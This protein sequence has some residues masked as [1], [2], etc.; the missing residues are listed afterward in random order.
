MKKPYCLLFFLFMFYGNFVSKA[1]PYPNAWINFSSGGT[2]S[3]QLYFRIK[4]GSE[5]IYRITSNTMLLSGISYEQMALMNPDLIQIFYRGEEQHIFVNNGGGPLS[6]DAGDFVEFYGVRNDGMPDRLM[7]KN[8][9]NAFQPDTN[10]MTNP[11]HS[12]FTDTAVYFFTWKASGV[13]GLRFMNVPDVFTASNTSFVMNEVYSEYTDLYIRGPGGTGIAEVFNTPEYIGSEG[14]VDGAFAS[15]PDAALTI[16]MSNTVTKSISTPNPFTS[17]PAASLETRFAAYSFNNAVF[18]DHEVSISINGIPIGNVFFEGPFPGDTLIQ[19]IS[20]ASLS[21]T[22]GFSFS[23]LGGNGSSFDNSKLC[24]IRFTYPHTMAFSGETKLKIKV[25]N[26]G[27]GVSHLDMSG[28]APAGS[29]G[30][31]MYDLTNKKKIFPTVSGSNVLAAIPNTPFPGTERTCF[32]VNDPT[33]IGS[34]ESVAPY[35]DFAKFRNFN[36]FQGNFLMITHPSLLSQASAYKVFRESSIGGSHQVSLI[37]I[38]ELYDQ[39]MWGISKHPLSIRNFCEYALNE[40]TVKPEFLFLLGKSL[41]WHD[42]VYGTL[43]TPRK[44][45]NYYQE[46]LLPCFGMPAADAF[47]TQGLNGSGFEPAIATGRLSARNNEE[48]QMYLEKVKEYVAQEPQEWMKEG[49]HFCGGNASIAPTITGNMAA[50]EN[51]IEDS[52]FGGHITTYQKFTTDPIVI[53]VADSLKNQITNGVSLMTFFGD[54]NTQS[55]DYSTDIPE[56]YVNEKKYPMLTTMGCNSGEIFMAAST[57]AERFIFQEDKG[58]IA[59]IGSNTF[60]YVSQ[61][62]GFGFRFFKNFSLN[63]YGQPIGKI[64]KKTMGECPSQ[65]YWATR[66]AFLSMNLHGDPSLVINS[67]PK[68]DLSIT[69]NKVYTSPDPVTTDQAYFTLSVILTNIGKTFE[70]N[71]VTRIRRVFPNLTDTVYNISCNPVYYLDTLY[72]N[73]PV[74]QDGAGLNQ[75]EI[76][77][78]DGLVVDEMSESNNSLIVDV[79]IES[80]DLIPVHP[81][82]YGIVSGTTVTLKASTVNAFAPSRTYQIELD[83]T[84]NY[85]SPFYKSF[86]VTQDGGVVSWGPISLLPTDSM[87]YFWRAWH[88]PARKKESTFTV[89]QGQTGWSQSRFVQYLMG[90]SLFNLLDEPTNR[91][92]NFIKSASKIKI[93]THNQ[94]DP[95]WASVIA[96]NL[97]TQL[98]YNEALVHDYSRACRVYPANGTCPAGLGSTT[99]W[100]ISVYDPLNGAIWDSY[101]FSTGVYCGYTG[102]YASFHPNAYSYKAFEFATD[103]QWQRDSLKNFLNLIPDGYKVS[104]YTPA[105]NNAFTFDNALMDALHQFGLSRIDSLHN[106]TLSSSLPYAA[107]GRKNSGLPGLEIIAAT[108]SDEIILNDTVQYLW[109]NGVLTTELIGPASKWKSLHWGIKDFPTNPAVPA[110]SI[111]LSVIGFTTGFAQDT[112]IRRLRPQAADSSLLSINP[113]V[114]PYLKMFVFVQDTTSRTPLQLNDWRIYHD[115][116]PEIALNPAKYKSFHGSVLQQGDSMRIKTIVENIGIVPMSN[117]R[118]IHWIRDENRNKIPGED[119]LS[120]GLQPGAVD[121]VNFE[122]STLGIP[123]NNFIWI[124]TNPFNAFHKLEQT[125][126]NNLGYLPFEVKGDGTNPLLDVTFD[127]VHILNGDIVSAK[128]RILIVLKDENKFLALDDTNDVSVWIKRPGSGVEKRIYFASAQNVDGGNTF[129]QWTAGTTSDNEFRMIYTPELY[130][131]GIYEMLVESSDKSGNASGRMRYRISFE[132]INKSTITEVLN[133]PN[134]FS[135][136]TRF[137]FVL[138]GSE[139]PEYFKIQIMTITGKVVREITREQFGFIHIGRNL[140]EY[141]W[142]GTDE[143]G[144]R[145]ANGVYLYRVISR[146]D[147]EIIEHRETEAD[148]YF[149]KGWGKMYLFH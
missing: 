52:L 78:D 134:P 54:D 87:V 42:A 66:S 114:Y 130:L 90:D 83:T 77:L 122:S 33:I 73:I 103:Q 1:Q 64:L 29:N 88:Q 12:N 2:H 105:T 145:L 6:F 17:G 101:S 38:E 117:Y 16:S 149:K 58:A 95:G 23:G 98:Y 59:Y 44:F 138:T 81:P 32:L 144:D 36:A 84:R 119:A 4:V 80:T 82:K 55:F 115:E 49:L 63:L 74:T 61:M 104:F 148:G 141:V 43:F 67:W 128:P 132:V 24:F 89:I 147:G 121:T 86:T 85:N 20:S 10:L 34:M 27:G 146:L 62:N 126:F 142:N 127:G 57:L 25:P 30:F 131:D 39:F 8:H 5:G 65:N 102:S 68:P 79:L 72:L 9:F 107:T 109:N 139:I 135:T 133:Y 113:D 96:H 136:A 99:P 22:T 14:W 3:D 21:N 51:V 140:S 118:T 100:I 26:S 123:G 48:V 19:T 70:Q 50:M 56:N 116:A 75:F 120:N 7:Y 18:N 76:K 143:Y 91:T 97:R 46:S 111:F 13:P 71:F 31:A 110:D 106:D 11:Y 60:A 92:L 69:Q 129:L 94:F 15:G 125:H 41:G 112:L 40:W 53:N 37:E 35:P 45:T 93:I 28:L 124:E 137:A 47:F 108:S